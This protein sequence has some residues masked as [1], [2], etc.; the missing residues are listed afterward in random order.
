[1]FDL[2]LEWTVGGGGRKCEKQFLLLHP[3]LSFLLPTPL[4]LIFSSTQPTTVGK[5]KMAAMIFTEKLLS[6]RSSKDTPVLLASDMINVNIQFVPTPQN[7]HKGKTLP[8]D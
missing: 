6:I 1:M 7:P 5:I 4:V 3:P 8:Y 2:V